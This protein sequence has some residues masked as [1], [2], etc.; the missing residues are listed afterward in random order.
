MEQID[1]ATAAKLVADGALLVD[2][3]DRDEHAREHIPGA[4]HQPLQALAHS[5]LTDTGTRIV[6]FHCRSG[7]RTAAN[8]DA[9]AACTP[10]CEAYLLEGGIDAWKRAGLPV[11]SDRTQPLELHRQVQIAAGSLI[12][13]GALL[14][15][16]VVPAWFLLPTAIGA[17]LVFAG[18]SG[19]CGLARVLVRMP[20]NRALRG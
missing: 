9:L 3:R 11:R 15:F 4:L 8:A 5:P 20:W 1:A 7:M 6:V 18:V 17:G 14:G 16:A 2:V 13:I 19:F 12:V 10:G